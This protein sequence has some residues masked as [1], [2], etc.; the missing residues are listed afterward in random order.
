[1]LY[2]AAVRDVKEGRI[3]RRYSHIVVVMQYYPRFLGKD[4]VDEYVKA[5]APDKALFTEFKAKDRET[6]DHNGAFAAV[7]YEARFHLNGKGREELARLSELSKTKDVFLICQCGPSDC[8]HA[9]LL[10]IL[11]R[12]WHGASTPPLRQ[13][14]PI[15]EA[16]LT[17]HSSD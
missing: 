12:R 14:Y 2:R 7:N 13:R 17:P 8:C 6:K 15:F 16:N 10:L 4:K 9:D 3:S 11:A 1:M 5:L